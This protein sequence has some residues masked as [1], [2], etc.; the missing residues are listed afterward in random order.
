MVSAHALSSSDDDDGDF[1]L[2]KS[3]PGFPAGQ[4]KRSMS[5]TLGSQYRAQGS[6]RERSSQKEAEGAP[7]TSTQKPGT[8]SARRI[9]FSDSDSDFDMEKYVNVVQ[10]IFLTTSFGCVST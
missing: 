2:A 1:D 9:S 7:V 5:R 6:Q 4:K 8:S 10:V 3:Q